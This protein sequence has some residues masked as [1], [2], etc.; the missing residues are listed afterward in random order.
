MNHLILIFRLFFFLLLAGQAGVVQAEDYLVYQ[1]MINDYG[2][3]L[4]SRYQKRFS[5]NNDDI[6]EFINVAEV[7]VR[8][9]MIGYFWRPWFAT[10]SGN[11][12]VRL[13][14]RWQQGDQFEHNSL[15]GILGQTQWQ[16]NLFPVSRFPF[17]G[18][19]EYSRDDEEHDFQDELIERYLVDFNQLY[20][21]ENNK[22]TMGANMSFNGR[23]SDVNG[24]STEFRLRGNAN[25]VYEL[26][27]FSGNIEY[28][29]RENDF[30]DVR[31]ESL[32][33]NE[34]LRIYA[35]HLYNPDKQFSM[36]N[37]T[38]V[39]QDNSVYER[40]SQKTLY[41]QVNNNN[42]WRP[43]FEPRLRFTSN[44]RLSDND[45]ENKNAGG[46]NDAKLQQF[47]LY[48][49]G[50]FDYSNTLTFDG[51]FNI[52][53]TRTD[54]TVSANQQRLGVQYNP[55]NFPLYSFDYNWYVSGNISNHYTEQ[56]RYQTVSGAIGQVLTKDAF[57]LMNSPVI[58]R[59]N[60]QYSDE[61]SGQKDFKERAELSNKVSLTHNYAHEGFFSNALLSIEDRR[62]FGGEGVEFDNRQ[63]GRFIL[64][65]NYQLGRH[66]RWVADMNL[67]V[68]NE[69][70][71]NSESSLRYYGSGYI[72]YNDARFF[73]VRRL[74]FDSTLTL[75]M[76]DVLSRDTIEQEQLYGD[77]NLVT[78][79]WENELTYLIG[80]MELNARFSLS[81]SK[82]NT[83][84]ILMFEAKRRFGYF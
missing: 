53:V 24:E 41:W 11:N 7:G 79:T 16:T 55:V 71:Q 51:N 6:N 27:N 36:E 20:T 45:Y 82:G 2:G 64:S 5:N 39:F 63:T 47:N 46:T 34:Q 50:F 42:F 52:N 26:H 38:N 37:F 80:R 66:K 69:E 13:V 9:L 83:N 29:D 28:L 15:T 56:S 70:L 48:A 19:F 75:S 43:D 76:E 30:E 74:R 33:E 54:D 49:G 22:T 57:D 61:I 31:V 18:Y 68:I 58:L 17:R 62:G 12:N 10:W 65:G 44:T 81:K 35:R 14:Q 21:S 32:K 60:S 3:E 59:I 77:E 84:G 8:N 25:H 40:S 67:E 78:T 73:D 23:D 72:A 4:S 1:G